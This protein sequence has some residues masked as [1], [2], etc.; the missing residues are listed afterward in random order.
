VIMFPL[1]ALAGVVLS[2]RD[3]DRRRPGVTRSASRPGSS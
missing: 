3:P 2:R 1:A